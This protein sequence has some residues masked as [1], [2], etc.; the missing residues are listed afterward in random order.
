MLKKAIR[1]LILLSFTVGLVITL[2]PRTPAQTPYTDISGYWGELCILQ[3]TQQQIIE[4]YTDRT[5]RPNLPITRAEFASVI[6]KAFV[7][8]PLT[9]PN[10]DFPDISETYWAI[11][12]IQKAVQMGFMEGYPSGIFR[13]SANI[14]RTEAIISITKGLGFPA[15]PPNTINQSFRDSN[16]IPPYAY[17]RLQT[18][19]DR[20]LIV[21]YPDPKTLNPTRPATRGE[22]SALICQALQSQNVIPPNYIP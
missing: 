20:H 13:P 17:T 16:K 8:R 9:F 3:L 1:F 22:V 18:A 11:V 21:N 6:S 15:T 10:Q 5:F 4:G 2:P 14:T 7:D 12:P 19:L